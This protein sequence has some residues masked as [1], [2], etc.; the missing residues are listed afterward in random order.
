MSTQLQSIWLYVSIQ[1]LSFK[2][3]VFF[4]YTPRNRINE[5]YSGSIFIFLRNLQIIFL[6]GCTVHSLSRVW[7]FVTPWTAAQQATLSIAN[8]QSLLKLLPIELVM[9]SN[10]LIF[11]HPLLLL[12]SIFPRIRLF[13]SELIFHIRWLKISTIQLQHQSFQ[14]IF[15]IDFL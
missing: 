13:S 9:P 14:W 12:P 15:S 5:S 2:N 10:H 1:S 7:L 11:C 6:S 3:F 8:S 4:T